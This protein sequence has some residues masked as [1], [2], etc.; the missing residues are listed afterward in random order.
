MEMVETKVRADDIYFSSVF[1]LNLLPIFL[2]SW[3]DL[4]LEDLYTSKGVSGTPTHNINQLKTIKHC[5][6]TGCSIELHSV[7]TTLISKVNFVLSKFIYSGKCLI[8]FIFSFF[9]FFCLVIGFPLGFCSSSEGRI[10]AHQ[11]KEEMMILFCRAGQSSPSRCSVI[12]IHIF[13]I[14]S[15]LIDDCSIFSK[16]KNLYYKKKKRRKTLNAIF[17][18]LAQSV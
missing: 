10:G 6:E 4:K 14:F 16:Q 3:L 15:H 17:E 11:L 7:L 1:H 12:K 18:D 5:K 13:D 8:N 9:M 2:C